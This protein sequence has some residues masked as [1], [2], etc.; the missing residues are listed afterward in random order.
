MVLS[1]DEGVGSLVQALKDVKMIDDT[2]I[3]F[4]SDN[5]GPTIGNDSN[6]ASNWPLRGGKVNPAYTGGRATAVIAEAV[7]CTWW[8]VVGRR[9]SH[10]SLHA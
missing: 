4:M 5:G 8:I 7:L 2:L 10:P 1:I 6:E 9:S 3:V